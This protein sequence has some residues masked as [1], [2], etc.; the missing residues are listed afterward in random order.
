MIVPCEVGAWSRDGADD[1]TPQI[2]LLGKACSREWHPD[3]PVRGTGDGLHG[4]RTVIGLAEEKCHTGAKRSCGRSSHGPSC[5]RE[6]VVGDGPE[7]LGERGHF[8]TQR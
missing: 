8:H 1:S 7:A 2:A 3:D 5:R 6:G 4:R